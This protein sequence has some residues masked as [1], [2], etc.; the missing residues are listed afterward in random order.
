MKPAVDQ[1]TKDFDILKNLNRVGILANQSSRCSNFR[2]SVEIIHNACKKTSNSKVT[3]IFGPQHG[4]FQTEQDN[5]KETPDSE[6]IFT[7]GKKVPLFSLYSSTRE[8]HKEHLA[9]LDTLIV[10]LQDIGCRV[11]TYMLTLAACL[12]AASRYQKKVIVLDRMNPLGLCFKNQNGEYIN[13]E[14]NTLDTKWQSFVGWYD[15]PM[16]HGL[17][18]GELGKYF[19]KYDKLNLEYLVIPVKKLR[20]TTSIKKLKNFSWTMPSP[21]IPS[22][23]SAFFFCAFV[24]LEGT[25]VSEG[26]GTTVPFQLI[27]A[28]WLSAQK[29]ISFLDKNK[30]LFFYQKDKEINLEICEHSFRPTF[31]KYAEKMCQGLLFYFDKLE[32]IRLFSLGMT[33]LYFCNKYHSKE[34]QWLKHGY[35]YNFKDL[36]IHL[37]LGNEKWLKIFEKS[38]IKD[39]FE[40][41]KIMLHNS[42]KESQ[43]FFDK[44]KPFFIYQE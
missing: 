34:F 12:R 11:Y 20:R 23:M 19:I 1:L 8:P 39:N 35:E 18:L 37:I 15:L 30:D 24:C 43:I 40:E 26:R 4:Y 29:L 38:R 44:V 10:D 14:G 42:Q 16:R 27:G 2:P 25:N 3:C 7:D 9:L 5:M 36:P 21:N 13:I 32:N 22:W 6:Y 31:N 41:F 33:F 17:S 28:P